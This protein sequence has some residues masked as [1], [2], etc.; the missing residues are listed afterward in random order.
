[1]FFFMDRKRKDLY[2]FVKM[3]S[4]GCLEERGRKRSLSWESKETHLRNMPAA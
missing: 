3:K 2:I 4:K 1:M